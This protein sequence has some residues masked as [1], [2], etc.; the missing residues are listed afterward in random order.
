MAEIGEI[1]LVLANSRNII[2][3]DKYKDFPRII[4]DFLKENGINIS[5]VTTNNTSDIKDIIKNKPDMVLVFEN[6]KNKEQL[7]ENFG[8]IRRLKKSIPRTKIVFFSGE[9]TQN[10]YKNELIKTGADGW[11]PFKQ[12]NNIPDI[13]NSIHKEERMG[14]KGVFTKDNLLE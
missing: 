3:I 7:N 1:N 14:F 8:F 10:S 9:N 2:Q 5:L 12:F 4:S 13:L 6:Y 11:I